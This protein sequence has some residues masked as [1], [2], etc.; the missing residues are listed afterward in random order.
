L[1]IHETKASETVDI[2]FVLAGNV[3]GKFRGLQTELALRGGFH[4]LK[5]TP[6]EKSVHHAAKQDTQMFV[7]SLDKKYFCD[8][9]GCEDEW[10]ESIHKKIERDEN[11][12]GS[13]EF[14]PTS[15][16]MQGLIHA[17][18]TMTPVSQNRLF[19]Q[20][21]LFELLAHQIEQLRSIHTLASPVGALAVNDQQKLHA[22]KQFIE[23]HFLEDLTLTGL[24]QQSM[25]NE[26]KLKKGFKALFNT[27]VIQYVKDLR[28]QYAQTLLQ[29]CRLSVTEVSSLL[30]YQYPNHFSS[31]YKKHFGVAPTS[32][33]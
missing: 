21:M 30:R 8:L 2:N 31:A 22:V 11:F 17:V 4:N 29:N 27:S 5:Y 20:S 28:M 18:R 16:K 25:L 26:F 14:L 7:I 24:C 1:A 12:F 15:P 9:I 19:I 6:S 23:Q 33:M 3:E 10:A 32:L 13:N